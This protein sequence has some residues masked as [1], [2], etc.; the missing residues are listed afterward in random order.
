VCALGVYYVNGFHGLV[1][2]G[3]FDLS[4]V[5]GIYYLNGGNQ[6]VPEGF[7]SPTLVVSESAAASALAVE[8]AEAE[9]NANPP[10]RLVNTEFEDTAPPLSLDKRL[11][12]FV[13]SIKNTNMIVPNEKQ[14]GTVQG[15]DT[16]YSGN[17]VGSHYKAHQEIIKPHMKPRVVN[18]TSTGKVVSDNG[19]QA[20]AIKENEILTPSVREMLRNDSKKNSFNENEISY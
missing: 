8:K 10:M 5:L 2:E 18:P 20:E 1:P 7:S 6:L 17:G 13:S 11:S 9:A 4:G 19:T 3:F 14:L 16:G 15:N 12:D